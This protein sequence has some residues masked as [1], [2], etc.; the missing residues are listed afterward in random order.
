[1][2]K[3]A[4]N[5]LEQI[6]FSLKNIA[7]YLDK[8][9]REEI[10][11]DSSKIPLIDYSHYLWL[12]KPENDELR[13]QLEEYN[14]QSINDIINDDFVEFCR[15]IYLQIEILLD[16][17]IAKQYGS[18]KVKDKL[19]YKKT[20]LAD[21]FKV[22]NG[23]PEN[24]KARSYE[25]YNIITCIMDIRDVASHGDWNGKSIEERIE[26]K[27]KSI[28]ISLSLLK[29]DFTKTEIN[30]IFS[31]YLVNKKAISIYEDLE[32]R[33]ANII[34]YDLKDTFSSVE[35]VVSHIINNLNLLHYKLGN[36]VEVIPSKTQPQNKLK[37][38][39][40]KK[41]Y[42]KIYETIKWFIEK[43]VNFLKEN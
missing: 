4:Q 17:F 27:G 42:Q 38:F 25:Q 30:D 12:N 33:T 8:L 20:R 32:K 28:K 6:N 19:Y 21:F 2:D 36:K 37:E 5:L 40:D 29:Y 10:K 22:I 35:E 7:L 1:M 18:D 39:F 24:F 14:S 11:I 43:I 41:D 34:L 13:K 3:V 15:K 31:L 9:T 23:S 16:Q 26:A